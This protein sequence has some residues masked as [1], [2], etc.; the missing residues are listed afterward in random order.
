MASQFVTDIR[1]AVQEL[2]IP[3]KGNDSY[4]YVTISLGMV[5]IKRTDK[6]M[7]ELYKMADDLLYKVKRSGKNQILA[8]LV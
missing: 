6:D 2:A 7:L 3:H 5:T 1:L 4:R 8:K